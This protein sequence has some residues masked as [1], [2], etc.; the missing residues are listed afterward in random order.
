MTL[1][2]DPS[3][4]AT[5][6]LVLTS[7]AVEEVQDAEHDEVDCQTA[8]ISGRWSASGLTMTPH[9]L[10]WPHG[11]GASRPLYFKRKPVSISW[12]SFSRALAATS[13]CT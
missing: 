12:A 8:G 11:L 5:K 1:T 6:G 2:L 10:G 3:W 4:R 9:L 7:H 13:R